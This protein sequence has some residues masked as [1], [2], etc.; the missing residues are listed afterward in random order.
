[1]LYIDGSIGEGGGQVLRTALALSMATGRPFRMTG[2]RAK[3][4]KPGL[5]RQ[6]LTAVAAAQAVSRADVEGAE[7]GALELTFTPREVRAG[8]YR[9]AVGTAGS[10]TL[11]LQTVLPVL[12]TA[13]G[14]S[15]LTLEGGTHNPMAPPFD[16]LQRA[17]LPL[18]ARMGP[19]LE[20]TLE[21]PGFYPAGGGRFRVRIEPVT[22]LS[23]LVVME[24]G[25]VARRAATVLLS[26]LSESIGKRELAVVRA[27]LGWSEELLRVETVSDAFGP[28]N[29]M[30]LEIASEQVTEVFCGFGEYGLRAEAVA[31]QA[32]AAA[33][34][35]LAAGVP[36]GSHLA[37]QLLVPMALA[38]GGAFRTIALSSHTT[39]NMAVIRLF[40]ER[41][42]ITSRTASRDDVTVQ[43]G[44]GTAGADAAG[45]ARPADAAGAEE[46]AS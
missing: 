40:L 37:D 23:P 15:E 41:P 6:H 3:R 11:V 7:P 29:T 27:K 31:E 35:Y 43:V 44:D 20:A 18:V 33:R 5:L 32:V 21:R 16:F 46:Q 1:V 34:R 10:A 28:G 24:R 14:P 25:A 2:I 9:F 39:T 42:T 17:F 38:G 13:P 30:W 19:R 4:R 8:E 12:L 36:I 26:N 22:R 45:P